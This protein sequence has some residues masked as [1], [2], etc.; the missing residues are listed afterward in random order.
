MA[1]NKGRINWNAL[2]V[3]FMTG[4][5]T[6]NELRIKHDIVGMANFYKQATGWLEEREKLHKKAIEKIKSK[7]LNNAVKGWEDQQKLWKAVE[8]QAGRLLQ[9]SLSDEKGLRPRDL[10]N[11]AS[12]IEKALK[13]Q[14][15][16]LGQSTEN[17]ANS[18]IHKHLIEMNR[19]IENNE[20][21]IDADIPEEIKDKITEDSNLIQ[22]KE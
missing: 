13:S 10:D 4:D 7:T 15:L 16:I 20:D 21:I 9:K 2:K 5:M 6:L 1:N 17:V 22:D 11:L 3:E 14:R 8:V 12:A 19:K 18:S